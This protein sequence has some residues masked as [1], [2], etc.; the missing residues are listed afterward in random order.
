MFFQIQNFFLLSEREHDGTG[1]LPPGTPPVGYP[2]F[3]VVGMPM[4]LSCGS[5]QADNYVAICICLAMAVH[6][7]IESSLNYRW[8][9][10]FNGECLLCK[11][12][13]P[14]VGRQSKDRVAAFGDIDLSVFCAF[15]HHSIIT[16]PDVFEHAC[17]LQF[18][19]RNLYNRMKTLMT[20]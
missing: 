14:C 20:F 15:K 18:N 4:L 19:S 6:C 2:P 12:T 9:E 17:R 3:C 7:G 11:L 13:F 5:G 1:T 16:M 10:K 8:L